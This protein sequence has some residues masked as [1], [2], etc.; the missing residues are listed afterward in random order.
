V[1][2]L[3]NSTTMHVA[4][5]LLF[6]L[7]CATMQAQ[8]GFEVYNRNCAGCHGERGNGGEHG[9]PIVNSIHL[10]SEQ[11]LRSFLA[12]GDAQRGMPSFASLPES[13][14][15]ML[16]KQ[17]TGTVRTRVLTVHL[18]DGTTLN[19]LA[20]ARTGR[21]LQLRTSDG[22]IHL[23]RHVGDETYREA[24]SQTDWTSY[25]GQYS[26]NRYST[27]TQI[28]KTNVAR[29]APRW[30]YAMPNG[31][32]LQGTPLV[33]SGI[34]Y[35]PGTNTVVALDAG[36]GARLWSF[37][38]PP[39]RGLIG[40]ARGLGNNRG[41]AVSGNRIFVQSDDAHL[42]ALDRLSGKL[43]WETEMADWRQNYNTT[44]SVLAVNNLVIAGTAGG[45]EGVRGFLAA[46]D[47]QSGKEVWRLWTIP[48]K[49][50]KGSE[51]WDGEDILHGGGPTWLTGSYDPE[52][53]TIYWGTGNAGPDFNGDK[54][55][56][57]NLYT[58]TILALDAATGK[59]KWHFQPTPHDEWDWDAVQPIVLIDAPWQGR[60][61]RL[62]L[63]A[64]RNGFLYVLDR[65]DGKL[66]QA[67]PL[68]HKLTWAREIDASGRPVMNPNQ[69]PTQAG[70]LICPAVSGATNFFSTSF[71]PITG[72][73]Y[74]NT[75]EACNIISK[76]PTETWTAGK[77]YEGG[78]G[79]R[80]PEDRPRKYLRAFEI[81]PA[82]NEARNAK[83]GEV[84][85]GRVAWEVAQ[86]GT[87]ASWT[88]VL[89]TAPGIVFYGDDASALSAADASTGQLLWTFPF[90]DVPHSSPM[91]YQFDHIQFVAITN[92]SQV[93]AFALSN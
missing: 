26:G 25:N 86:S 51:T 58:C 19:G 38:R 40:N 42:I 81:A 35:V 20:V 74:V 91:T 71:N 6:A 17:V 78:A 13:D 80:P 2:T 76:T 24:T 43:L 92:G 75:M 32:V 54:R 39:T 66:L 63:Q 49:G 8:S 5:L 90:A 82:Q 34:M 11:D 56:G 22:I 65:T 52:T 55:K 93:Y 12:S 30:V 83:A 89:S 18:T 70:T 29:L 14:M 28:N 33:V 36:S 62:L 61:R 69:I 1:N 85:P 21:E 16:V 44:G 9:P 47:Q 45:E 50:E 64:S 88:G 59:L 67:T 79:S 27:L 77:A 46:Y 4:I 10:L 15:A 72:L 87:G 84:K 37:T 7:T 23:L 48:A 60:Q 68:V 41:L 3:I 53:N 57:D 73:Y 31:G